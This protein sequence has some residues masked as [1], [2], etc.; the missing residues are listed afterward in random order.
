MRAGYTGV[1]PLPVMQMAASEIRDQ[2]LL[3]LEG[4]G[5]ILDAA[6][7]VS[8]VIRDGGIAAGLIGGMALYALGHRQATT[9]V[10]VA[11]SPIDADVLFDPLARHGCARG[12]D[13]NAAM[14]CAGVPIGLDFLEDVPGFG[15]SWSDIDG[16]R[17]LSLAPFVE[18]QLRRAARSLA[19]VGGRGDVLSLIRVHRLPLSFAG[20]LS[21]G[22]RSDFRR[23]VRAVRD[24]QDRPPPENPFAHHG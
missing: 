14:V 19:F 3:M 21:R 10:T 17:V 22:V 5:G 23:L 13:L 11:V 6:R 12:G 4:R 16:L 1:V 2:A 7:H 9:A 18:L 8:R 24:A 15:P 20:E